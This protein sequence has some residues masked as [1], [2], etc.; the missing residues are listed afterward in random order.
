[1]FAHHPKN[2][3]TKILFGF[4]ASFR[5]FIVLKKLFLMVFLT[6]RI[7][8]TDNL[9]GLFLLLLRLF[10]PKLQSKQFLSDIIVTNHLLLSFIDDS[11]Q[12]GGNIDLMD[13]VKK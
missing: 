10:D 5:N 9:K 2:G 11:S 1:M 8:K 3:K 4:D 12:D 13:H 6:G 7:S